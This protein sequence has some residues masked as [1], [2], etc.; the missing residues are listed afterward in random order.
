MKLVN[1]GRG[2]DGR[3]MYETADKRFHVQWDRRSGARSHWRVTDRQAEKTARAH[4]LE[5]VRLTIRDMRK[6][7]P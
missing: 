2:P 5:E 1:V 4:T 3:A 6:E 7:A